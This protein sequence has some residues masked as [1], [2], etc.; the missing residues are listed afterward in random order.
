M[1]IGNSSSGMDISR[2]LALVAKEVHWAAR[3]WPANVD[4][5]KR[6]GASNNINLHPMVCKLYPLESQL[7][8]IKLVIHIPNSVILEY[9][10]P[11]GGS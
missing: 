6:V 11:C 4:L 9:V 7:E 5:Q 2:E 1:V 10:K 3:T 8:L